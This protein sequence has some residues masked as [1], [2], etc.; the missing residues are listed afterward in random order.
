M[1]TRSEVGAIAGPSA[2]ARLA[3]AERS[4]RASDLTDRGVALNAAVSL[5]VNAGRSNDAAEIT[6]TAAIFLRFLETGEGQED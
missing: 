5:H 6:S 4:R 3:A 1:S 2:E